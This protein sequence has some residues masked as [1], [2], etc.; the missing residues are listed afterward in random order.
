MVAIVVLL[1]QV[2]SAPA[3]HV[4]ALVHDLICSKLQAPDACA[5]W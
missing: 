3:L 5:E 1:A 2:I 4:C